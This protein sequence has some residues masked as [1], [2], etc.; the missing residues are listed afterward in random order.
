[1][2]T[3]APISPAAPPMGR[4]GGRQ[5]PPLHKAKVLQSI[6]A[7]H[8]MRRV[9]LALPEGTGFTYKPGQAV[10]LLIETGTEERARRDYTIRAAEGDIITLDIL[11]H[12]E[13]PGP[14]WAKNAKPGDE[15]EFRGPRGGTWLDPEADW[16]LITGD[17]TVIPAIEHMLETAAPGAK[18]HVLLEIA[19]AEKRFE[20]ET[21][22]DLTLN[23]VERAGAPAGPSD[24]MVDAVAAFV[25]PE[26]RGRLLLLGETSN[27]RRQ[28]R[29]MLERGV[30][31]SDI[32]SEGYWRPG[33]LGGHDHVDD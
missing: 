15:I 31:K 17:E 11:M 27:V 13:T 19:S 28:R 33:R 29:L 4:P 24:L 30:S 10:V 21:E 20:I 12:G 25:L 18:I 26:G 1:M 2:S 6:D 23:W 14:L 5:L 16:H 8:D 3:P 22:A 9:T 7:A 32:Y